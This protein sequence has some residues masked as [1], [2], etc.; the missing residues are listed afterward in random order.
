[1]TVITM[2]TV[3]VAVA[4]FVAVADGVLLTV[5]VAWANVADGLGELVVLGIGV[6]VREGVTLGVALGVLVLLPGSGTLVG[7][8]V[9]VGVK[10]GVVVGVGVGLSTSSGPAK[11][12]EGA[13]NIIVASSHRHSSIANKRRLKASVRVEDW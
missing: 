9:E 1:M 7:V 6:D 3:L 12:A 13:L 10:R 8:A 4:R 11:V 5:A 2:G